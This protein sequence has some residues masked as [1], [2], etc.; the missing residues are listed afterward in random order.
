[1]KLGLA[2][3]PK[4]FYNGAMGRPITVMPEPGT[5][6]D[7]A[8]RIRE[9]MGFNTQK[10]FAKR[11]GFTSNQWN[12]Y[13]RGSP[14]SRKAAQSLARQIPGLT[15]GWIIENESAGLSLEM[16]RKLGVVPADA[17]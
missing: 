14:I 10:A 9:A 12:N 2:S 15:V 6:A 13:E 1:M 5:T 7:R 3:N 17:S 11:Y 4:I 8:K 16:A